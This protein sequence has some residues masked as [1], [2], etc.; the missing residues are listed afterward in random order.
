MEKTSAVN[1]LSNA[2]ITLINITNRPIL[3]KN[4]HAL[5]QYPSKFSFFRYFIMG[6]IPKVIYIYIREIK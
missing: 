1:F 5:R 6:N 2:I 4:K 3:Q